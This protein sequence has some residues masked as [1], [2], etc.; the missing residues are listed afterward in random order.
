MVIETLKLPLQLQFRAV[1]PVC[2]ADENW[3]GELGKLI[4]G[5]SRARYSRDP[6]SLCTSRCF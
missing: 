3:L 2:S 4:F 1:D 6:G 5:V